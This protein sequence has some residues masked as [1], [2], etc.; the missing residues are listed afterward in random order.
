MNTPGRCSECGSDWLYAWYR[1]FERQTIVVEITE[2]GKVVYDYS[3]G[4]ESSDAGPDESYCCGS[5]N[6][7][8][9]SI[10]E[11]VGLPAPARPQ[12]WT[13]VWETDEGPSLG[14]IYENEDQAKDELFKEWCGFQGGSVGGYEEGTLEEFQQVYDKAGDLW[15]VPLQSAA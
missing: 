2:D 3:G 11:M 12:K 13:F 10:E 4:T 14:G 7:E 8:T 5:C 6:R 9:S 15:V 1:V